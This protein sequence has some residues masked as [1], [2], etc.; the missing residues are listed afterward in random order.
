M[1]LPELKEALKHRKRTLPTNGVRITF[2][3]AEIFSEILLKEILYD[4]S[5]Y[6]LYR[7]NSV[8][9]DICGVYETRDSF[10]Y[11]IFIA[12]EAHGYLEERMES[13]ILYLYATQVLGGSYLLSD[14]NRYL[15]I[16]GCEHIT[17]EGFGLGG[18][19]RNVYDGVQRPRNGDYETAEASIQ[20]YIRK[21]PAGQKA[22]EEARTLAESLGYDLEPNET[23]VRPFIRQVF[24]LKERTETSGTTTG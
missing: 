4:N 5:I 11:G 13:M 14:I 3:G 1:D 16:E 9:G 24:R 19:L 2:K 18:K 12:S 10:F 20:G 7:L 8:N 15:M 22:S 21:L 23:Y 6:M 17:A